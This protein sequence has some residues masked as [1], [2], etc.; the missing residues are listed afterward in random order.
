M[1][2]EWNYLWRK[3]KNRKSH[4]FERK[5]KS[6]Q[7]SKVGRSAKR[8][9]NFDHRSWFAKTKGFNSD[10]RLLFY[11]ASTY[12][13]RTN[14]CALFFRYC[15]KIS[16]YITRRGV[17]HEIAFWSICAKI[18]TRENNQTQMREIKYARKLVRI[19]YSFVLNSDH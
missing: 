8:T 7:V 14:F 1:R 18:N 5:S 10:N 6:L 12:L 4:G 15:A 16:R 2:I 19:R 17:L 3:I 13:I 9:P 11:S